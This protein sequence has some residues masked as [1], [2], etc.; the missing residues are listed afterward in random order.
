[1]KEDRLPMRTALAM[2]YPPEKERL[3]FARQIGVEDVIIW[4]NTF[5]R[6]ED[7]KK[8]LSVH[9]WTRTDTD[10]QQKKACLFSVQISEI[11]STD[12]YA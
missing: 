2:F 6:K 11:L 10:V 5:C 4:G 12:Q 7:E 8:E 1:M 3:R 9:I